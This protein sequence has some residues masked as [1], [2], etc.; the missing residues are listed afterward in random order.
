M[1]MSYIKILS[2][3]YVIAIV[4]L[5]V[6]FSMVSIGCEE[7]G[8]MAADNE[9]TGAHAGSDANKSIDNNNLNED[10][11]FEQA[12]FGAGCFWGVQF[13]FDQQEGVV[14]TEAGYTGGHVEEPTYK[15]VCSGNTGH[16]EAVRV[17]FDP[18]KMS[19]EE[20]VKLFF[21][22]HDPTQ[23]NRQ[24]PDIGFQYRSVVFYLDE[25]Q[26]RTAEDYIHKLNNSNTLSRPVATAVEPAK[27]FYRAE[28]YHQRYLEK[29]GRKSCRVR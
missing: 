1:K 25:N 16:T 20:L 19:Y 21:E 13:T 14:D 18:A 27:T 9:K 15:Q 10:G 8:I 22:L 24:G 26:K 6:C 4:A 3:L 11:K 23:T 5:L 7:R 28:E 29:R 12:I 2:A 17:V